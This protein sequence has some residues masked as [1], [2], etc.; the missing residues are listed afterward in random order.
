MLLIAQS[1][2]RHST[3]YPIFLLHLLETI[4]GKGDVH[5][6]D[7]N[8]KADVDIAA[9]EIIEL[10]PV[11]ALL[12]SVN[13]IDGGLGEADDVARLQREVWFNLVAHGIIPGSIYIEQI[14]DELQT[15]ALNSGALI[16]DDRAEY[17]ESEIELNTVLRRGMN[18]RNTTEQ[19]KC[20]IKL[21]PSCESEIRGLSYPRV[22]FLNAAHLVETSRATAGDCSQ[23]LTYFLDPSLNGNAMEICVRAI[24]DEVM[25]TYL[26]NKLAISSSES[27]APSVAKQLASMLRGCCHRIPRVQQI[28]ALCADRIISQ[29]PSALC[30]RT[31]L[32]ALLELLTLMW[33][34]CLD[35][36]LDE[37]GLKSNYASTLGNVSIELSDNHDLRRSTLGAFHQRA[38][39][40]VTAV[41]NIA[42][43]DIK[44]LLQVKMPS[45]LSNLQ[46]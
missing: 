37:Y 25:A 34:S 4:V 41:I 42:P 3:L 45:T 44:G 28:A 35:A 16:A 29:I 22:V 7:P 8:R 24:A 14:S 13:A 20:L 19:K 1:L 6:N 33:S 15:L 21:L 43:L 36:E 38:K 40:W 39:R 11:L 27:S 12:S 26:R 31:S 2:R 5:E 17:F 18:P 32:F 46:R 30:Q 9:R 23:I 10:I